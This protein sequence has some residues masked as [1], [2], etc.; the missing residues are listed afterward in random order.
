[1]RGFITFGED[2]YDKGFR[3]GKKSETKCMFHVTV[4]MEDIERFISDPQ[5]QGSITGHVE[6]DAL[7]GKLPVSQGWFNLFVDA[8]EDGKER[9]LMKYRLL[10]EDGE[11]HPITLDGFKE[12]KDDLGFDVWDDTTTLFTHI[13]AGHVEPGEPDGEIVATGILKVLPVDFAVQMTT[14]RVDPPIA[15]TRSRAS[16]GC[17]PAACRDARR[18]QE[19]LKPLT[20][21]AAHTDERHAF[22]TAD[23]IECSVVH[24]TGPKAPTKGP[25]LLVHGV[26]VRTEIWRPPTPRTLVEALIDDGYDVWMETWRASMDVPNNTWNLDQAAVLDH[27]RRVRKVVELTGADSIQASRTAR[28]RRR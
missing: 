13:L 7:G 18:Q 1:M 25:V 23:G 21:A 28:A 27:R 20:T 11:G 8:D 17:S 26:G 3:Q 9:K 16:A 12:V 5:H 22:T 14:F 6:C 4:H 24:V 10:I 2:D 19:G 15:S